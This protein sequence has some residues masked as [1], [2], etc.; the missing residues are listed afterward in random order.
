MYYDYTDL[1]D[2]LTGNVPEDRYE[3][4]F[5]VSADMDFIDHP[6]VVLCKDGMVLFADE[7][8]GM[9][10]NWEEVGTLGKIMVNNAARYCPNHD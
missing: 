9:L 3:E 10:I 7:N 2:L 5:R 1:S 4:V 8:R 6:Q